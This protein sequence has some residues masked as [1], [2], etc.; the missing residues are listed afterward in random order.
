M[1]TNKMLKKQE[2]WG[3]LEKKN[4]SLCKQKKSTFES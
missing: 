4:K 2:K 3:G 1:V